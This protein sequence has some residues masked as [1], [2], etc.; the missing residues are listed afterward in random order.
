MTAVAHTDRAADV[1][2]TSVVEEIQQWTD[3]AQPQHVLVGIDDDIVSDLR[4]LGIE[5]TPDV[6]RDM[7]ESRRQAMVALMFRRVRANT[8][9]IET[10]EA[11]RALEQTAIDACYERQIAPLAAAV[12]I[13]LGS[14]E[15]VAD[16][17]PWGKKK[18][19]ETP[20]GTYGVRESAATVECADREALTQWARTNRP[21]LVR[22]VATLSYVDAR[23]RF[24]EEE[25]KDLA[26][27]D[28][29]W[30]DFKKT[31]A[32]DD[33]LPPGVL[34]VPAKRVPFAKVA[35]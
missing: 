32:L 15:A 33:E 10:L 16:M 26:K 35:L 23:E 17:T 6:E 13:L 28:V 29:A 3:E 5:L 25:M 14:I 19:A 24:T 9:A 34:E 11:A 22:V 27:L 21:A 12:K 20:Y 2:G 18:S 30:G 8:V 1:T 7:E 4:A 31:L